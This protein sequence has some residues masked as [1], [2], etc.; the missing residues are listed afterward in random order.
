MFYVVC[1]FFSL[2]CVNLEAGQFEPKF[3][4]QNGIPQENIDNLR[5][6]VQYY[7]RYNPVIVEVGGYEGVCTQGFAQGFPKGRVIVFEPNPKAFKNLLEK[8]KNYS[9]VS[10]HN[11]ALSTYNGIAKLNICQ[12]IIFLEHPVLQMV[13]HLNNHQIEK[14]SSLLP[15][16]TRRGP[17]FQNQTIDVP[18]VVLDDW[19]KQNSIDRIDLLR[20]DI[21]G[22]ELQVLKS[23]PEI[24]KSVLVICTRTN[25]FPFRI[26][27]TQYAELKSFL[28]QEGFELIGHWYRESIY[29]EATFV[30]KYL[31][32]SIYR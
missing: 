24:L 26:G 5:V 32:D 16:N 15:D 10:A 1:V 11:L 4:G 19:C 14:F 2:F 7:L 21:G 8:V 18:C 27:T 25:F 9:N 12:N 20:L 30:R 6:S 13:Q 31:Y 23:S 22:F 17:F 29:G 3:E 28:E